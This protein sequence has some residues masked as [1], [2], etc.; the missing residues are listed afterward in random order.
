VRRALRMRIRLG[1]DSRQSS[2]PPSRRT[3]APCP[4]VYG[5]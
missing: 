2:D 1:R 4:G 3:A 5:R